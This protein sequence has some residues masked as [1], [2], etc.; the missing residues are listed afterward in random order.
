MPFSEVLEGLAK[1]DQQRIPLREV[2]GAVGTRIHGAALLLLSLPEAVPLPVP[3]TSSILGIP[4]IMISAHLVL[5]GE[6]AGLPARVEALAIPRKTLELLS[7]Y[8]SPILR[9]LERVSGPRWLALARKERAIGL[10]CIYLGVVLV[11]PLPFMNSVPAILLAALSWGLVQKD[12]VAIAIGLIGSGLLTVALLFL[13]SWLS[14][15]ALSTIGMPA[16]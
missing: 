11:L 12:G 4:I 15:V 10:V 8:L 9:R 3:S 5:F 7:R 6:R 2:I 14:G 16:P 1:L 13:G